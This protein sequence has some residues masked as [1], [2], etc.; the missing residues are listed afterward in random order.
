MIS[1]IPDDIKKR[2]LSSIPVGRFGLPEEV[3]KLAVF[4]ASGNAAY[5]TG[6]V[7]NINGGYLMV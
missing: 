1:T 7:L 4:L 2:F 5:I 3:A 6:Q